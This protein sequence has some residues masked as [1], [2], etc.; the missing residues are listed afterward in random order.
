[1]KDQI[2]KT[3]KDNRY[4]LGHLA[5]RSGYTIQHVSNVLNQKAPGSKRFF[6]ILCATINEMCGSSYTTHDFEDYIQ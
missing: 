3:L 4:T 2:K 6:F 5:E 1:M